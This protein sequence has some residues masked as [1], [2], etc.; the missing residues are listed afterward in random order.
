[1]DYADLRYYRVEIT[2][3]NAHAEV[4]GREALLD[5]QNAAVRIIDE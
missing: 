5:R 3:F 1:M 4:V 2:S